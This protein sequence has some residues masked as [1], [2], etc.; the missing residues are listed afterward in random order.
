MTVLDA[1]W[2]CYALWGLIWEWDVP[3]EPG[4]HSPLLSHS[5]QLRGRFVAGYWR[6]PRLIP[7]R[8]I[9]PGFAVN[10]LFYAAFL[11][12]LGHSVFAMRRF[13][14]MKRGLCVKCGYPM[15]ESAVCSECGE[16]LPGRAELTT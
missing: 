6:A 10:T 2:P 12:L 15:G 3:P 5:F 9:W 16:E 13:I 11:W 4:L 1:G 14:R 8:P 7:L